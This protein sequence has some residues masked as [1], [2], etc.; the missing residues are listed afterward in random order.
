MGAPATTETS[1][2]RVLR[3]FATLTQAAKDGVLPLDIYRGEHVKIA[4]ALLA[5][6]DAGAAL[7]MLTAVPRGFYL[8]ELPRM[9]EIDPLLADSAEVMAGFLLAQG[10][11][12]SDENETVFVGHGVGR[13]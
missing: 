2:E 7:T 12:D 6:G 1:R 13:A 9:A 5:V 11:V 10:H 4:R 3:H 8:E